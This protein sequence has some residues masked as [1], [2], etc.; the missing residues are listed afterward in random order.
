MNVY[1]SQSKNE[2][3]YKKG[4]NMAHLGLEGLMAKTLQQNHS[5]NGNVPIVWYSFI[6]I[7]CL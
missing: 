1:N 6:S 2:V 5:E 3:K 4:I 7:P